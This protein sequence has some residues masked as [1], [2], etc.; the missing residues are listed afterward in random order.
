[1]A[2]STFHGEH[3]TNVV[4]LCAGSLII[5]APSLVVFLVFQRHFVRA[6][7]QGAIK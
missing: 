7:L 6:V 4:L 1:V 3:G 5:I 2:L